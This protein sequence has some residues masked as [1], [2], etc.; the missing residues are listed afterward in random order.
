[1]LQNI[2]EPRRLGMLL[3]LPIVVVI[4]AGAL[5]LG[6]PR[7]VEVPGRASRNAATAVDR[8]PVVAAHR[9]AAERLAGDVRA[10]L[11]ATVAATGASLESSRLS[12]Q[13][14]KTARDTATEMARIADSVNQSA[15]LIE[16]I[17]RRSNEISGIVQVI[18]DIAVQTMETRGML[19]AQAA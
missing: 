4:V 13:C 1:M 12:E 7:G 8:E 9:A 14:G 16:T 3:A 15:L 10:C 5:V 6:A 17:S 11:P 18:K 19:L 2:V